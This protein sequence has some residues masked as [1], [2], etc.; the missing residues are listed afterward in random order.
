M[1]R[2]MTDSTETSAFPPELDGP[3]HVFL[4]GRAGTGKTTLIRRWIEAHRNDLNV[5]VVAPTGVAALNLGGW[6]IHRFFGFRNQRP[7]DAEARGV[8][9]DQFVKLDAIVLDEVSMCRS[10]L[11]DGI[12]I[13]L[14]ASR[15]SKEPFGGVRMI[16]V[17]DPLQLPP[18]VGKGDRKLFG[19]GGILPGEWFFQS[20]VMRRIIAAGKLSTI[21]LTHI[22]RQSDPLFIKAL[23]Y[24]RGGDP[25]PKALEVINSRAGLPF[26]PKA[27]ILTADNKEADWINRRRLDSLLGEQ[28]DYEATTMGEWKGRTPPAPE[29]L[30]L[31][32]GARVMATFNDPSGQYVNGSTG[33]ITGWCDGLPLVTFDDGPTVA[34]ERRHWSIYEN[35][36]EEVKGKRE[37]QRE[38]IGGFEQIPLRLGWAVTIHKSQGMTFSK[39]AIDWGERKLFAPGQAY[40]ALSRARSLDGLTMSRPLTMGDVKASRAAVDFILGTRTHK[41][42]HA[43]DVSHDLG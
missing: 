11:M 40:V 17:G 6:T 35:I 14:R 34:V 32:I 5:A 16:M 41:G 8:R 38:E 25:G 36:V 19:R 1:V 3:N 30:T 27:I 13:A 24:I 15:Y 10:D 20:K 26:D 37:V 18:V 9:G 28:R 31:A 42:N 4:T 43:T 21:E 29:T 39:V 7:I 12:D 2:D 33:E 22:W 23:N